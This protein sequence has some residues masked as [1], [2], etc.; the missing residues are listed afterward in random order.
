LMCF[1]KSS[2]QGFRGFIS[3]CFYVCRQIKLVASLPCLKNLVRLVWIDRSER[4]AVLPAESAELASII[5]RGLVAEASDIVASSGV[6]GDATEIINSVGVAEDNIAVCVCVLLTGVHCVAV[7][8]DKGKRAALVDSTHR[9]VG[10]H[11]CLGLLHY[12][13]D[14]CYPIVSVVTSQ[15]ASAVPRHIKNAFI[16]VA[17]QEHPLTSVGK[18]LPNELLPAV[19]I[20]L[21]ARCLLLIA[22][23]FSYRTKVPEVADANYEIGFVFFRESKQG[24]HRGSVLFVAVDITTSDKLYWLHKGLDCPVKVV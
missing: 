17:A 18:K 24:F 7:A 16:V 3:K 5:F 22:R 20:L 6:D 14:V 11:F 12:R 4:P 10:E 2:C 19:P 13:F 1:T 15:T 23:P 21:Q 9:I 8:V